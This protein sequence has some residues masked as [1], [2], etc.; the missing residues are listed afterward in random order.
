MPTVYE[1]YILS[2]VESECSNDNCPALYAYLCA[3]P[4]QHYVKDEFLGH[5][6]PPL[7]DLNSE[8]LWLEGKK[9]RITIEEV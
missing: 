4:K 9:V 8:L 1:G 7:V 5:P 2:D 6:E 3:E